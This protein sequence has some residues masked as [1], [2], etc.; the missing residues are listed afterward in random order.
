MTDLANPG[1]EF[2]ELIRSEIQKQLASVDQVVLGTVSGVEAQGEQWTDL[3]G[4]GWAESTAETVFANLGDFTL[5]ARVSL[6]DWTP[7]AGRTIIQIRDATT[8]DWW[9]LMVDPAG[10]L[11]VQYHRQSVGVLQV[12]SS[13]TFV[14]PNFA[15]KYIKVEFDKDAGGGLSQASFWTSEDAV[16][17]TSHGSGTDTNDGVFATATSAVAWIGKRVDGFVIQGDIYFVDLYA[18]IGAAVAEEPFMEYDS[19]IFGFGADRGDFMDDGHGF[20]FTLRGSAVVQ[21]EL[22]E[23]LVLIDGMAQAVPAVWSAQVNLQR[24]AV[25]QRV[26]LNGLRGGQQW[27]VVGVLQGNPYE[28]KTSLFKGQVFIDHFLQHLNFRETDDDSYPLKAWI[29]D[30]NGGVFRF[31][32]AD[33][34]SGSTVFTTPIWA[35]ANGV[36]HVDTWLSTGYLF[37]IA[38]DG[39]N[40]GGEIQ[41]GGAGSHAAVPLYIDR[42]Q[43]TWRL[44]VDNDSILEGDA[45]GLM[46]KDSAGVVQG[47]LQPNLPVK[48][49]LR[50]ERITSAQS[51]AHGTVTTVI[52]NSVIKEDDFSGNFDLNTSNGVVLFGHSGWY[53]VDAGILWA[54]DADGLRRTVEINRHPGG[55]GT[56]RIAMQEMDNPLNN[57]ISLQVSTTRFFDAGDT[58]TV[59]AFQTQAA[60]ASLNIEF[61]PRTFLSVVKV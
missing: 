60:A 26:V 34:T 11:Q 61:D 1:V 23:P 13:S 38:R 27:V 10:S 42:F 59:R 22:V 5:I 18:G 28:E 32:F 17:W 2:R 55:S 51:I 36:V 49:A 12:I 8:L 41:F 30:V 21:A 19:N 35:E 56:E 3:N 45:N 16:T 43:N 53:S 37:A 31:L 50:G 7:A 54:S 57:Q 52:Y 44:V 33:S 29:L 25:N 40:E 6:W 24:P 4:G 58:L 39:V 46:V 48:A 47:H 15:T 9:S 14:F 20:R